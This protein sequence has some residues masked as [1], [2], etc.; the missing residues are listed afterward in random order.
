VGVGPTSQCPEKNCACLEARPTNN[1]RRERAT[2]AT[3][4]LSWAEPVLVSP[5]ADQGDSAQGICKF[6]F[7]L[8]CFFVL[9]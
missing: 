9:N 4:D 7:I 2:W 1:D 6:L 3:E 8:F 5:W